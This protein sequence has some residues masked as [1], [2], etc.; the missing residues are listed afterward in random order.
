MER[1]RKQINN[2]SIR[3]TTKGKVQVF[4]PN[5]EMIAEYNTIE[6]AIDYAKNNID[7]KYKKKEKIK[8]EKTVSWKLN[9]IDHLCKRVNEHYNL[10]TNEI[11]CI[12]HYSSM[13]ANMIVQIMNKAGGFKV[14]MSGTDKDLVKFLM[15][16]LNGY[17]VL[18]LDK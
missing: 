3:S 1:V 10:K 15:N 6:E 16:L 8:K 5:K 14:L 4:A 12:T 2:L 7:Y 11:G 17:T 18:Q 13:T 9:N